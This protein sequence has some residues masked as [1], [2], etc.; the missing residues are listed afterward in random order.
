MTVLHPAHMVS[1]KS[2]DK[3]QLQLLLTYLQN[4]ISKPWQRIPSIIAIFAAEASLTLLDSSHTQFNTI[5]KF[6]MNSAFVDM[7]S[8]PLFPTLLKSSSVHFKAD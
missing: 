6:L 7:Q 3:W 5:S 1:Q 2:K 8:I 4:G